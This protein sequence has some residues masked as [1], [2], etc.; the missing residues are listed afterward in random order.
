MR[1]NLQVLVLVFGPQ[2]L[3]LR[4]Q[5]TLSDALQKTLT[6]VT[7]NIKVNSETQQLRQS[8]PVREKVGTITITV[9]I[10]VT[11]LT[12]AGDDLS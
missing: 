1:T 3:E 4:A 12:N 2:H 11:V 10:N 7:R 9:T 8:R 6:E 5:V